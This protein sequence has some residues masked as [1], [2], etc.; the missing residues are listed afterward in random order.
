MH[1][2]ADILDRK[3]RE[4]EQEIVDF[5]NLKEDEYRA[6]ERQYKRLPLGSEK[7]VNSG[8]HDIEQ[9]KQEPPD[10]QTASNLN[11]NTKPKETA[12]EASWDGEHRHEGGFR[13]KDPQSSNGF[14]MNNDDP[15]RTAGEN[16]G[17]L[18]KAQ[19]HERELE[20][21]GLFTPSFLPLLNGIGTV[22]AVA[23]GGVDSPNAVSVLS[24][25]DPGDSKVTANMSTPSSLPKT[26]QHLSLSPLQPRPLSAS[27]PR[28]PPH[29]RRSSSRSDVSIASLRSSLRDPKQPRSPK[30]VLFSIGDKVVSPSTSPLMQRA[31]SDSNVMPSKVPLGQ[32]GIAPDKEEGVPDQ[33]RA[34]DMFPWSKQDSSSSSCG[35]AQV[36]STLASRPMYPG[37]SSNKPPYIGSDEFEHIDPDDELF[38]FDEDIGSIPANHGDEDATETP[39]VSDEDEDLEEAMPT[40]SPHAGSLPIEI[41]WPSKF[42]SSG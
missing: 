41:K 27:V 40:N 17:A 28:H 29:K 4:L 15:Q 8:Y 35:S 11:G 1:S 25:L 31:S 5:K 12:E 38:S 34:W 6:F 10:S 18:T 21:Q 30:R 14:A 32:S 13:K 7:S 3:R 22:D 39:P 37:G 20:F 36:S 33:G 19:L 2:T 23:S 42:V 16:A 24:T 26:H 9:E